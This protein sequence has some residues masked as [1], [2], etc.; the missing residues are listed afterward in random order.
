MDFNFD[1]VGQMIDSMEESVVS[2]E[3]AFGEGDLNKINSLKIFIFDLH[4]KINEIL[5]EENV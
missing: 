5:G 1:F 2:L 4:K 3:N